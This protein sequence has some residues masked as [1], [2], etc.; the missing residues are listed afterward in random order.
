VSIAVARVM[1]DRSL[2]IVLRASVATRP[3]K[4][5]FHDLPGTDLE[6][7]HRHRKSA[8]RGLTKAG[9]GNTDTCTEAVTEVAEVGIAAGI[10]YLLERH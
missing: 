8:G 9:W 5:Y 6:A 4:R 7:T 1:P 3:R 2:E 10:G